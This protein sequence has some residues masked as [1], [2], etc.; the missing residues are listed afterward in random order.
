[1][2]FH[3]CPSSE[4]TRGNPLPIS[5]GSNP[6]FWHIRLSLPCPL[7]TSRAVAP[8]LFCASAR[9]SRQSSS[10]S[11]SACASATTGCLRVQVCQPDTGGHKLHSPGHMSGS[12]LGLT[13]RAS[14]GGGP[15]PRK[16]LGR[17]GW[18]L[19]RRVPAHEVGLHTSGKSATVSPA[20]ERRHRRL[21]QRGAYPTSV[22]DKEEHMAR[23]STASVTCS[24]NLSARTV[25]AVPPGY[26]ISGQCP[27]TAGRW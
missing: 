2:Q 11:S 10:S 26:A 18:D 15:A 19:R 12:V 7:L 16:D 14:S 5:R 1:M 21:G 6:A 20:T 17:T 27:V 8:A 22:A 9:S 3:R 23:R 13:T 24:A 25:E 4:S